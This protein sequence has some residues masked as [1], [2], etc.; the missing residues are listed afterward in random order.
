MIRAP[1]AQARALTRPLDQ[2]AVELT[3]YCNLQCKM[4]SVW[5]LREHG[6]PLDL[7]KRLLDDAFA[8]G[9]RTFTPCGAESFM[10]KDFLDIVEHAHALGYT[11]Q[12]IVTNGTMISPAHMERLAG[13]PSV[14]LHIS[15]DGPRDVQDE[16]RGA[17]VYDKCVATAKDALA[18]G[19]RVG[20]SGVIM[21]ETLATLTHLV[22]LACELGVREVSYQPFQTEISGP[23]KD[24]PR[25]SL[26]APLR[27]DLTRKLDELREY[28]TTRG[29]RIYTEALFPA[30]P[31]YLL[32]GKRPIPAGGCY[33]P[34]KFLL[35]DWRG[36]VYPCFFMREDKMGNVYTDALPSIWHSPL[37]KQLNVLALTE[38]CPG[39]LAAC[40]DVETMNETAMTTAAPSFVTA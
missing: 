20:L 5:E 26:L 7:A 28:A 29:V 17:G 18:R 23:H 14:Q 11:T 12:E 2:L 22:D 1:L 30:I 9:A 36:D 39:C 16:L 13:A 31:G 19:I 37:Q 33:L 35:V 3:V 38:R 40:S 25:F 32:E 27:A 8:L 6:V 24:I 4:C 21:R 10:R 15:I 34:S